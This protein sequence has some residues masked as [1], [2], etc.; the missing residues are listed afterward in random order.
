MT[1]SIL[2]IL[3]HSFRKYNI[4]KSVNR[5]TVLV[6]K[7]TSIFRKL[8]VLI[9]DFTFSKSPLIFKGDNREDIHNQ[10]VKYVAHEDLIKYF[11]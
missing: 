3:I 8:K 2:M 5:F 9:Y 6:S 7:Q 1:L 4:A 10:L 11:S